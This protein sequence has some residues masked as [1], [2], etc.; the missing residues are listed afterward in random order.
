MFANVE[1]GFAVMSIPRTA[2]RVI[3]DTVGAIVSGGQKLWQ[4]LTD[5]LHGDG[6][7]HVTYRHILHEHPEVASLPRIIAFVR[8]PW[9]RV[10]STYRMYAH[11]RA[12]PQP[13]TSW[14]WDNEKRPPHSRRPLPL[15]HYLQ[16]DSGEMPANVHTF[17]FEDLDREFARAMRLLG[18]DILPAFRLPRSRRRGLEPPPPYQAYYPTQSL[19]DLVGDRF[20]EDCE[21]FGY[22][23]SGSATNG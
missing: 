14:L 4:P 3:T 2:S 19:V 15:M 9:D 5:D 16:N 20:A 18:V 12:V 13:F 1:K 7:P 22:D 21:R 10:V 6:T 17:R 8:N 23:F 11:N